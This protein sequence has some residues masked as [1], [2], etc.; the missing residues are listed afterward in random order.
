MTNIKIF[1]EA[2]SSNCCMIKIFPVDNKDSLLDINQFNKISFVE[3]DDISIN[4]ISKY[5][6]FVYQGLVVGSRGYD[7]DNFDRSLIE[8]FNSRKQKNKLFIS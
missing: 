7:E 3:A 1:K 6:S 8:I 4:D 5:K 2:I